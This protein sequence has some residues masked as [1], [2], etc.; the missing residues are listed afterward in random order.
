MNEALL[1][2]LRDLIQQDVCRRGLCTDPAR[3]LVNA[4]PEDFGRAC[5]SLAE[6]PQP[7]LAIVTGFFIPTGQPPCGETD[8]PLGAVFLARALTPLGI[9]VVIATDG[10]C[11]K[12]IQAGLNHSGLRKSVPVVT[13]PA[14]EEAG[15]MSV[16]EY[17]QHFRDR[18]GALTHLLAIERVGPSHTRSSLQQQHADEELC[19]EVTRC[20]LDTV[21][22]D[23]HDCC[24][25]MRGRDITSLMSPAHRL[26][27]A[28]GQDANIVTI[29]IGDGGNEI[30]MG[31]ISWDVIQRNIPG[32][33]TVACRVATRHLI[34]CGISNWGGYA[35]GA[36][37][38]LLRGREVEHELFNVEGEREILEAMVE[39]GPLVDGMTGHATAT[40]DGLSFEK[41][42]EVLPKLGGICRGPAK[43]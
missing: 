20:F 42:A 25:T 24:H 1:D 33:G 5:Q 8:G 10:F 28:V 26:F 23:H 30:G 40:V 36:G 38:R 41:Y 29:G 3:N 6:H 7:L 37:V 12:A 13:L 15:Q 2:R 43:G 34:V 16:S 35:L 18:A 17:W 21:A 39:S 22:G 9:R 11:M 27:E 32:G 31:K 19:D 14:V 4:C